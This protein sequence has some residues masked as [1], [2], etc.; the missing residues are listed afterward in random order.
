MRSMI[1][2]SSNVCEVEVTV[3]QR[4]AKVTVDVSELRTARAATHQWSLVAMVILIGAWLGRVLFTSPVL[5][6][7]V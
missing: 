6:N 5:C 4:E 2:T 7:F 1:F 3:D